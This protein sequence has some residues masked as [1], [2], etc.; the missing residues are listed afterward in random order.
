MTDNIRGLYENDRTDR[1]TILKR[2]RRAAALTNPTILP[3]ESGT[4]RHRKHTRP[5]G[6]YEYPESYTS[7]G[8]RGLNVMTGKMLSALFPSTQP[9]HRLLLN[10]TIA[11][12]LA[13]GG[14]R[15][16]QSLEEIRRRL[17]FNEV[18]ATTLLE[19]NGTA[20][21]HGRQRMGFRSRKRAALEQLIVTGSV[22]EQLT[23][24]YR[25]KVFDRESYVTRRDSAGSILYHVVREQI[26]P[27][28][29]TDEQIAAID[30]DK[31]ELEDQTPFERL[32]EIY[33]KVEWQPQSKTWVQTQEING[34]TLPTDK[35]EESIEHEISPYF[36][37]DY[38]L[39][40]GQDYGRGFVEL[41]V[42]GTLGTLN[43]LELRLLDLMDL[44]TIHLIAIDQSSSIRPRD[45]IRDRGSFLPNARVVGG[46]VQDVG[47]LSLGNVGDF[48]SLTLAIERKQREV[49]QTM[50]IESATQPN[51]DRVTATQVERIADEIDGALG[52]MYTPIAD[53]QQRPLLRRLY[54]QMERDDLIEEM[55]TGEEIR[56]AGIDF[57]GSV[58]DIDVLTGI[59]AL[60]RD[61][62]ASKMIELTEVL[63]RF[64][65][66]GLEAINQD[67][68]VREY[69]RHRSFNIEGVVK[70]PEQLEA[71]RQREMQMLAQQ[72]AIATSG[73]VIEEGARAAAQQAT[74]GAAQ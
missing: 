5:R 58:V 18:M 52:G 69:M 37:T 24:D 32:V 4:D 20:D 16:M 67:V 71:E 51:K 63:S 74:Q 28:S 31:S 11:Q 35:G 57:S 61:A 36:A 29:L 22:L 66:R 33:T 15:A 23:P 25:V 6:D 12:R 7:I 27:L 70:S 26:D 59:S 2:A 65:D 30:L 14:E 64:G 62:N 43:E 10:K 73:N 48:Q 42:L 60:Q 50:L 3:D 68:F 41:N 45:M 9:W 13:N 44:A 38:A 53:D 49:A 8:Q 1:D 19:S 55:P 21:E 56:E 72:Q 34:E 54:W 40:P 39:A 46:E 17:F 47:L